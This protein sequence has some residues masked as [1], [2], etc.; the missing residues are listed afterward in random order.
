M[1]MS[2][3]EMELTAAFGQGSERTATE[4]LTTRS[5]GVIDGQLPGRKL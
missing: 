2:W 1:F 4:T 5:C 3:P